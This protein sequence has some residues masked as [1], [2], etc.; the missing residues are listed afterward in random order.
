LIASHR[1]A[2]VMPVEA[3]SESL[4]EYFIGYGTTEPIAEWGRTSDRK[5][6][7]LYNDPPYRTLPKDGED[8]L[9][10]TWVPVDKSA[11]YLEFQIW[12]PAAILTVRENDKGFRFQIKLKAGGTRDDDDTV[13]T[14]DNTL[15]VENLGGRSTAALLLSPLVASRNNGNF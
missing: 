8:T 13:G 10:Q 9:W 15:Q 6:Q 14:D 2:L 7:I 11:Q 4:K 1:P 5:T 3:S 12:Y